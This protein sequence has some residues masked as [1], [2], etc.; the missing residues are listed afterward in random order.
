MSA[1]RILGLLLAVAA[2]V[3]LIPSP[4]VLR[5][6]K[7]GTGLTSAAGGFEAARTE[8]ARSAQMEAVTGAGVA[9][10]RSRRR[11]QRKHDD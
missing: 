5:P 2:V 7:A 4:G 10:F 9:G 11:R 3:W 1:G 8:N 6:G